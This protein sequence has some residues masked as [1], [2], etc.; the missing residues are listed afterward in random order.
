[1][2]LYWTLFGVGLL[3]LFLLK[4]IEAPKYEARPVQVVDRHYKLK[5]HISNKWNISFQ[6]A[7]RIVAVADKYSIN[8]FP[9][10]YDTLAIIATESSFKQYAVSYANA[11]GLMQI[12]YKTT[13]FDMEQNILD[14]TVLLRDYYLHF[15]DENKAI[16]SYNVGIGNYK[17]GIRNKDYLHKV[18]NHK[19]ELENIK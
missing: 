4:N 8:T 14:G 6:Q 5:T 2:K 17:K 19:Q 7:N 18:K 12:L 16:E 15:K 11:K 3:S 1:M 10:V 9:T 13:S